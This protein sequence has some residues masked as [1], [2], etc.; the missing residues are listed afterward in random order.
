MTWE[1]FKDTRIEFHNL[2]DQKKIPTYI[3]CP[4]CGEKIYRDDSIIYAS[5]PPKHKY[6]CD[7]CDWSDYA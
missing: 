5:M 1:E 7:K 3:T 2:V 6:F 4:K